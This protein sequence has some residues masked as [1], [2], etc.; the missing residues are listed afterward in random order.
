MAASMTR[1]RQASGS[2]AALLAVGAF[3]VG[4][5]PAKRLAAVVVVNGDLAVEQEVDRDLVVGV[6]TGGPADSDDRAAGGGLDRWAL[7]FLSLALGG[8]GWSGAAGCALGVALQ[9]ALALGEPALA[10][11]QPPLEFVDH[12]G[13][14]AVGRAG[15]GRVCQKD[16]D[17]AGEDHAGGDEL[18]GHRGFTSSRGGWGGQA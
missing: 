6:G 16:G 5:L 17:E 18:C 1:L 8:S 7:R 3:E 12:G 4:G 11:V 15:T 2:I 9:P 14:A 13:G 10:L